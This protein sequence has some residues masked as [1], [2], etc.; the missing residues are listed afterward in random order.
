MEFAMAA[1]YLADIPM[2]K[3]YAGR[4]MYDFVLQHKPERILELGFAHG[5]STCYMAAALD[6]LGRGH[7]TT[8]DREKSR[9]RQPDIDTNLS[10][11]G[12]EQYVTPIW[13][14]Q[15]FT[16]ELGKLVE[17]NPQPVFDFVFNDG[18][19]S[20]DVAGY[21]F[22]LTDRLLR[23]GGWMLFDA[24]NWTPPSRSEAHQSKTLSMPE[25]QRAIAQVGM[26]FDLLVRRHPDY[27][28]F[29]V[30]SNGRWGWARKRTVDEEWPAHGWADSDRGWAQARPR[31]T[32]R[33]AARSAPR[34]ARG[35]RVWRSLPKAFSTSTIRRRWMR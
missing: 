35:E 26:V 2:M 22:F 28:D 6:E 11:L 34:T 9:A 31:T 29:H 1:A 30:T 19:R 23:P 16:W 8:L 21:G 10:V 15:S 24:L 7:I 17:A 18:G 4:R 13:S 33:A 25:E 14:S 12:L 20:W 32:A 27:T 5:V 3:P